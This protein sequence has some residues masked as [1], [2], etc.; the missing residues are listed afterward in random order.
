MTL[1]VCL[2]CLQHGISLRYPAFKLV[3]HHAFDNNCHGPT[4][5]VP[6]ILS[7]LILSTL[8]TP[9]IH[10]NI[11]ISATWGLQLL[12]V[13]FLHC[14]CPR[15][16]HNCWCYHR[17][18]DQYFLLDLQTYSSVVAQNP[19]YPPSVFPSSLYSIDASSPQPSRQCHS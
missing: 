17:L 10:L 2:Q 12:L 1:L 4:F 11:L 3:H 19:R 9:L 6:L 15:T 18:V 14:P 16:V 7:F 8:L 5:V 13:C